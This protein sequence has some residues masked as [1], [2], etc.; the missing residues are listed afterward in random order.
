LSE[1]TG[2]RRDRYS[3]QIDDGTV[4]RSVSVAG[5]IEDMRS[6]GSIIFFTVRD[7]HG[8]LQAVFNRKVLGESLFAEAGSLTRQS[9]VSIHGLV[10]ASRS[11]SSPYEVEASSFSVL[12][13]AVHPLPLDPTGRV[14]AGLDTRLDARALD[15][16]N[17]RSAAVFRIEA[18]FLSFARKFLEADGF[19]EVRTAKI[20]GAATEG[21]AELFA[22]D[23]FGREACL[24]QSPQLYKEELTLSLEKVYEVGTYF[25]AEKSHTTRHLN[26]FLGL[27]AEAALYTKEDAMALLEGMTAE[28]VRH[29]ADGKKKEFEL[30]G[31]TPELPAAPFPVVRYQDA[32]AEVN[33]KGLEAKFGDD[34]DG[35]AL[36][37]LGEAHPGYY[38]LTE[39]PTSIKPFYIKPNPRRPEVSESFDLMRGALELASGGER[40]ADRGTLEG[41]LRE[42]G[43]DPASF[44]EHLKAYDWGMPPHSGWGFGVERFVAQ[45]TGNANVREAV[46]YPRD[47]L[48]VTP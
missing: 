1:K 33:E 4:G 45:V 23:Y 31:Y 38:F 5:W 40:V 7:S 11:K 25:R 42:K 10:K 43:I 39:W 36:K 30:L 24:A 37:A 17:P 15:L 27:D 44:G 14:D 48:R 41:R 34:F 18:E 20:I 47:S 22:F 3:D 12:A 32:I 2:P 26:E 13:R 28:G 6:I 9:F 8:V 21:G 16:R 35:D 46:L 19:L 29:L